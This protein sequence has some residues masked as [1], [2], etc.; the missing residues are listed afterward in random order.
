MFNVERQ[1]SASEVRQLFGL[2]FDRVRWLY[3]LSFNKDE[4]SRKVEDVK[5]YSDELFKANHINE[6]IHLTIEE[7]IQKF[8]LLY[9]ANLKKMAPNLEYL[10]T[11]ISI[12]V[13]DINSEIN[14]LIH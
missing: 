9:P 7:A 8:T 14:E 2:F 10:D 6:Y 3:N 11:W 5:R 13:D 4:E 12:S 1:I